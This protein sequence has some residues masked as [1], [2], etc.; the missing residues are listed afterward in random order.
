MVLSVA[1]AVVY[2]G[3]SMGAVSVMEGERTAGGVCDGDC[4]G[5][6][7]MDAPCNSGSASKSSTGDSWAESRRQYWI[8]TSRSADDSFSREQE[9]QRGSKMQTLPASHLLMRQRPSRPG[10]EG[11]RDLKTGLRDHSTVGSRGAVAH[12]ASHRSTRRRYSSAVQAY[13]P[14]LSTR[15]RQMGEKVQLTFETLRTTFRPNSLTPT[16]PSLS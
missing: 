2:G 6:D 16:T 15:A 1:V 9:L 13:R 11:D 10:N 4:D 8:E 3:G 7:S 14:T 12:A 5:D